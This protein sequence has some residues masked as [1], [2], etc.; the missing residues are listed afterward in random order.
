MY[1]TTV[2]YEGSNISHKVAISKIEWDK[3]IY[4]NA[5]YKKLQALKWI[6]NCPNLQKLYVEH[7]NLSWLDGLQNCPNLQELYAEH[8]NLSSL[9]GLQNCRLL[10]E[11]IISN[12]NSLK[13]IKLDQFSKIIFK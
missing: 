5:L 6:Q 2:K 7:N 12:T 11:L 9:D 1:N 13:L 10:D 3:V 4:I 8:N